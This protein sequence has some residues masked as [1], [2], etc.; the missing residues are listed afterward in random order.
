MFERTLC[1]GGVQIGKLVWWNYLI[2]LRGLAISGYKMVILPKVCKWTSWG[3]FPQL[4]QLCWGM[5]AGSFSAS[6]PAESLEVFIQHFP[7]G[8]VLVSYAQRTSFWDWP[9]FGENPFKQVTPACFSTGNHFQHRESRVTSAMI[10]WTKEST[11][12][13]SMCLNID[14]DT[15]Q[16]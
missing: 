14:I 11:I 12:K 3:I 16:F 2:L 13:G 5:L 4:T 7:S 10:F 6:Y 8:L 15:L 9:F 1:Q